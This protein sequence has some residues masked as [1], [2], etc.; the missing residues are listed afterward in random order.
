MFTVMIFALF[1]WTSQDLK[2][3]TVLE[4]YRSLPEAQK[5]NKIS[6][7]P[8]GAVKLEA[9]LS[10]LCYD[11]PV[12]MLFVS[13]DLNMRCQEIINRQVSVLFEIQS[14]YWSCNGWLTSL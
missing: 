11:V 10:E 3:Y 6:L 14:V 2:L 12:L 8:T 5:T 1:L 7:V 4:T 9:N 13:G